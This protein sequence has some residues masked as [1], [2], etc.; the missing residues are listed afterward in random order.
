MV[1]PDFANVS[2]II[3]DWKGPHAMTFEVICLG[4]R[5][6]AKTLDNCCNPAFEA[7]YANVS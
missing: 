1:S 7:E 3:F 4:P 2:A 5:W 6:A